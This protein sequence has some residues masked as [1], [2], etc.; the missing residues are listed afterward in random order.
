MEISKGQ[1]LTSEY[2][3]ASN[4]LKLNRGNS[5]VLSD[6][7]D[8]SGLSD[9]DDESTSESHADDITERRAAMDKLVPALD[10]SDYGKMPPSFHSN[11]QSVKKIT[12]E[13]ESSPIEDIP[14]GDVSPPTPIRPLVFPRDEFDGVEDSDDESEEA[15]G[16][17]EEDEDD[18]PQ[19][20]GELEV[21]MQE[22]ADE[23][24]KFSREALGISS[25][26]WNDI[27]QDRKGRG[28]MFGLDSPLLATLTW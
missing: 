3:V 21:D 10:P 1:H 20:I 24:L 22:E 9:S 13:T 25:E 19:V 15:I 27:V 2:R 17:D 14:K 16:G 6:E 4:E 28:G 18:H 8:M 12:V 23:F 11:S 5:E 7:A 26:M